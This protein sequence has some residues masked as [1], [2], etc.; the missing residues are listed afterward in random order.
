M[1]NKINPLLEH[2]IT[3]EH[4]GLVIVLVAKVLG[5]TESDLMLGGLTWLKRVTFL[6]DSV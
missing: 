3:V 1:E 5:L 4:F 6:S 2:K